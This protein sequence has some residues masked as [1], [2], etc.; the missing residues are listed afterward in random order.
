MYFFGDYHMHTTDSDG[1]GSMEQM[2]QT[3]RKKGLQE[4]A[5]TDHGPRNIGVGIRNTGVLLRA[6][7][8]AH[9][10]NELFDG[11]F[12]ILVGVEADVISC[13]GEIDV[14]GEVYRE[15]DLLLVGLHPH[16]IPSDLETGAYLVGGNKL[17][18]IFPPIREAVSKVN[19]RALVAALSRHPVNIVTHP[20]LGMAVDI[21]A[22]ARTCAQRGC[23]FEI[24]TGHNYIKPS[25]VRQAI[26]EGTEIIV[27]SDAHF[28][29]TVGEFQS[30]WEVLLAAG[31][32]PD[33]V[34]NLT[35]KGRERM[36]ELK[37]ESGR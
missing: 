23:A 5:I 1:R 7:D 37:E 10:L 20:G 32:D 22:V 2:V 3:A 15:L 29:E 27:N 13:G 28:P 8:H 36:A 24:N 33:R 17:A 19:T 25:Q 14:P 18:Y 4:I 31:A 34:I 11:E 26:R 6:R 30:G 21:P 16:V 35:K 12:R 9:K